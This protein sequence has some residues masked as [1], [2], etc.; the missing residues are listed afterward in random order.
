MKKLITT[1][2]LVLALAG[3]GAALEWEFLQSSNIIMLAE[4]HASAVATPVA[5]PPN[6]VYRKWDRVKAQESTKG[7]VRKLRTENSGNPLT[8][9]HPTSRRALQGRSFVVLDGPTLAQEQ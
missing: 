2:A 7:L 6:A 9:D 4:V 1:L 3:P 5:F 8:A